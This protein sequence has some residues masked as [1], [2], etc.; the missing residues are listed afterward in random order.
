MA[1]QTFLVS[2]ALRLTKKFERKDTKMSKDSYEF[3]YMSDR[4][5]RKLITAKAIVFLS[6]IYSLWQ[7]IDSDDKP[8]HSAYLSAAWVL[9]AVFVYINLMTVRSELIELFEHPVE[10]HAK[11]FLVASSIL[12]CLG[13]YS[14]YFA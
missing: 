13:I 2:L 6:V 1:D 14:Q 3:S 8:I 5:K 4:E 10:F 11:E 12:F 9:S 7:L